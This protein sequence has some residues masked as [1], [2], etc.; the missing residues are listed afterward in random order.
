MALFAYQVFTLE[1]SKTFKYT[2]IANS[3][4]ILK[5]M[6]ILINCSPSEGPKNP[7]PVKDD[8]PWSEDENTNVDHLTGEDFDQ[9]IQR[10]SSVLVMFYAPCKIL[11]MSFL[12]SLTLDSFLHSYLHF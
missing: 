12:F 7:P 9:Y 4:I 8:K 2:C 5:F 6:C 3:P 11:G 1:N 10:H